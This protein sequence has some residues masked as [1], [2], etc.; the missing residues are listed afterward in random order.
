[1][2]KI[3][4]CFASI[5]W[6]AFCFLTPALYGESPAPQENPIPGSPS[7]FSQSTA[8]VDTAVQT[9]QQEIR[10]PFAT[11]SGQNV[12]AVAAVSADMPEIKVDLQGIGFG[13]KEAYA[14]IGGDIF[15]IGEEK[16]GIKLLEVRRHEVDILVNGGKVTYRLFPGQELEKAKERERKKKGDTA[17]SAQQPEQ[18]PSSFTGREQPSL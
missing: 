6:L 5:F 14:L 2:T 18:D 8:G 15:H 12:P 17:L 9:A 7:E 16:R 1:M 4:I 10:D 11:P 3:K 13:S